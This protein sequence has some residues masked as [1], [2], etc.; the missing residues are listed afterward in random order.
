[1]MKILSK[2]AVSLAC[3]IGLVA[4]GSEGQKPELSDQLVGSLKTTLEQRK[5]R[6]A[7][8]AAAAVTRAQADQS[9]VPLLRL[10]IGET[11]S[12]ATAAELARNG[13]TGTYL[14]ASGQALYMRGGIVTGTRGTGYDLMS[15]DMP[16]RSIQAAIGNS[17][18]RVHRYLDAQGILVKRTFQ[19]SAQVTGTKVRL[20]LERSYNVRTVVETCQNDSLSFQNTYDLD[21]SS[22]QV[23][24][25][26]Q[27]VGPGAGYGVIEQLKA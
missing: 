20:Q 19:C 3:M 5:N 22:D 13:D 10:T 1:M 6:G 27:W 26:R 16:Y 17:Y 9:T 4:C 18:Q 23:W 12:Q 7:P 14:M 25:S 21:R 24:W 2:T 8:Q 15:L 11:N